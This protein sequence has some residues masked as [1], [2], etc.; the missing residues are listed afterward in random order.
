[1]MA[2]FGI[3]FLGST[4]IGA[5]LVGW[6]SEVASP[7]WGMAIGGFAALATAAGAAYAF[8]ATRHLRDKPAEA[9]AAQVAEPIG[10]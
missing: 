8:R 5:P 6:V 1:V 7:R 3:V 10:V 2:L 9:P 4:P